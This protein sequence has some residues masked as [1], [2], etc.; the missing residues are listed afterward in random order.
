MN[1][2]YLALRF[3]KLSTTHL[4]AKIFQ[5][6]PNDAKFLKKFGVIWRHLASFGVVWRRLASFG[7]VW[8]KIASAVILQYLGKKSFNS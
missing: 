5:V 7:V 6:T 8:R 2:I 1:L 4:D 3:S